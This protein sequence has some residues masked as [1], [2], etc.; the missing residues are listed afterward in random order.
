MTETTTS[1][2][3][4]P[5]KP[6]ELSETEPAEQTGDESPT[7]QAT[8]AEA[9]GGGRLLAGFA[10]IL[11][12]IGLGASGYLWLQFDRSQQQQQM[13]QKLSSQTL[14]SE[15]KSL[16]QAL[17]HLE[18]QQATL[19]TRQTQLDDS[20]TDTL[21]QTVEP[22]RTAQ[23]ELANSMQA[24]STSVEKVYADL[25]RSLDSWALEEVE[26]L[27]RIAN[28]SLTLSGDAKTA[29][30][31]LELADRRLQALGDPRLGEVRNLVVDEIT[32][33]K[34]VESVDVSGL[35]LKL[36]SVIKIADS[37]PLVNQPERNVGGTT[38]TPT[39]EQSGSDSVMLSTAREFWDDLKR[40]VRIQNVTKPAK[41][42]LA[43]EQR[44]YL[45]AN[46]RLMLEGAQI[47][48][49]RADTGT[50]RDNLKQ[51][52]EWLKD[53]FD[54]NEAAVSAVITDLQEMAKVELQPELPKIDAS[55]AA[56]QK[57]KNRM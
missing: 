57:I 32:Q 25:D 7:T 55:L 15:I 26:Q 35:A 16:N 8:T 5:P 22:L 42:L 19:Q 12:L 23:T 48:L 54:T 52:N 2:E 45:Y 36:R 50:Y 41:P 20:V 24:L 9:K 37:L 40:Q 31:G 27:L 46:L 30:A 38:G 14:D 39:P 10:L 21:K 34:G 43:P 4:T 6:A 13:T 51:A 17:G 44:Y 47:A 49:L 53:Y 56:L 18:K 28:H 3:E 1:T 33:L 29:L 11:A